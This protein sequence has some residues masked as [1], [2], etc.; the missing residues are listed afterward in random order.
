MVAIHFVQG[1]PSMESVDGRI[2]VGISSCLLGQPVRFDGGHRLSRF[3]AD[4]L[5]RWFEFL[6]VC[7]ETGIGMGVP[8][9]S[10]QLRA[11]AQGDVRLVGNRSGAD[12]TPAMAAF[13][14]DTARRLSPVCGY[15]VS[16]KSPSCGLERIPVY[17]ENG[18]PLRRDGR[19]VFIEAFMKAN[20][21]VPVEEDG[22][23]NDPD[24]KESFLTRVFVLS[25]WRTLREQGLTARSLIAFHTDHKY[26]LM[27]HSIPVYR[28]LG[29]ML[30]D[31]SAEPVDALADRYVVRLMEGLARPAT[32]GGHANVLQHLLGYLR[33][34]VPAVHRRRLATLIDAYREGRQ[35]L[36]APLA[37]LGHFLADHPDP[38][39][40]T[41]QYLAPCP[42]PLSRRAF[43]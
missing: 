15:I 34:D 40:A 42:E 27:A 12:Y 28:E 43:S 18:Q 38:Y 4:D 8:R 20:P 11:D 10:V 14:R 32:R 9:E 25:R 41:Q 16:K 6:P 22:R 36:A 37:L 39:L 33:P 3:C 35:P 29:R 17:G 13:A 24:L 1:S 2:P 7:P 19:G 30:G 26:L 31:L 21:L 5:S 23:L